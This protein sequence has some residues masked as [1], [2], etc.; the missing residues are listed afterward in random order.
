MSWRN[1]MLD[2]RIEEQKKKKRRQP[3]PPDE[4]MEEEME[5]PRFVP[6]NV[7]KSAFDN[8]EGNRTPGI[9]TMPSVFQRQAVFHTGS[10]T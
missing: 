4:E 6:L 8:E 10:D 2:E 7:R 1:G 5:R 3:P 9:N